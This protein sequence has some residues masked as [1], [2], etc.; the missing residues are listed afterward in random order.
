LKAPC[1]EPANNGEKTLRPNADTLH[2]L[3]ARFAYLG[4]AA[5]SAFLASVFVGA[6]PPVP[7]YEYER[8]DGMQCLV[9]DAARTLVSRDDGT[10]EC[11]RAPSNAPA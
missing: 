4:S 10:P 2:R 9:D 5:V 7:S 3:H 11:V 6:A 8:V 1:R